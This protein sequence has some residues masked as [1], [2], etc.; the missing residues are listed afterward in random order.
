[1]MSTFIR[2]VIDILILSALVIPT[3]RGF[4][5][6]F[7]KSVLHFCRYLIAFA[8][9][10]VLAR[11]FSETLSPIVAF[12]SF[13]LIALLLLPVLSTV[14]RGVFGRIPVVKQA[15]RL[16][17][18]ALGF[19]IGLLIAWLLTF[20]ICALLDLAGVDPSQFAE[21]SFFRDM[22][23]VPGILRKIF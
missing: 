10:L 21:I 9:A 8:L 3:V 11:F 14:L 12:V 7:V 4:R 16:L 18:L 23:P 6:G 5:R 20:V 2:I 19:L 15:D 17:G 13:F 22:S 1:M